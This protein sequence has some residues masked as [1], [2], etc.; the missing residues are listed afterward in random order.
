M[1]LSRL[2]STQRLHERCLIR[3]ATPAHLGS[4]A[5]AALSSSVRRHVSPNGSVV[6]QDDKQAVGKFAVSAETIP[7]TVAAAS[8][9]EKVGDMVDRDDPASAA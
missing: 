7:E 9:Q 8:E 1:L 5:T 2:L 6:K 4:V 3:G